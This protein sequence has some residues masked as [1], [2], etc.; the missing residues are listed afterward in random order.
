MVKSVVVLYILVKE[1]KLVLEIFVKLEWGVSFDYL[2]KCY[3]KCLFGCNG[4]DLGE[5]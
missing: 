5:F 3:F 2:V 4:G 1:E